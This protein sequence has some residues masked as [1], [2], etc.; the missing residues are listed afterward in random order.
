MPA[1]EK[2]LE[3]YLQGVAEA[4]AKKEAAEMA[5]IEAEQKKFAAEGRDEFGNYNYLVTLKSGLTIERDSTT[6][7]VTIINAWDGAL[8]NNGT[9]VW[10]PGFA[11]RASEIADIALATG[12]EEEE[13]ASTD[14]I[15][16]EIVEVPHAAGVPA[17]VQG[18]KG[19]KLGVDAKAESVQVGA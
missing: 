13:D 9:I 19:K 4:D 10:S 12:E 3:E 5:A 8:R 15:P 18:G 7:P 17:G 11:T 1:P 2:T 6:E 16:I 14:E